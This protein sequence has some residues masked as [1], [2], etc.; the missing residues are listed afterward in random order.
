MDAE[1]LEKVFAPFFT[2][3]PI[4]QGTGLGLLMIYGFA[5]QSS[6]QVRVRAVLEELG[7]RVYETAEPNS[8][9]ALLGS[10]QHL[11]LMVSDVGFLG[12]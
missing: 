12:S 5:K 1:T 7:Y 2:T 8:A 4:G 11:D 6:G 9:S 3:R 10:G